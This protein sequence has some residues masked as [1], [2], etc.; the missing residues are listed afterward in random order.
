MARPVRPPIS[1][2][3]TRLPGAK[4]GRRTGGSEL[5]EGRGKGSGDLWGKRE[6]K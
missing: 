6:K 1:L 3:G 2:G 5:E 4:L